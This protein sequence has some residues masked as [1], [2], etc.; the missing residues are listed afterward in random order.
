MVDFII[1]R[2]GNFQ[3]P[4][5]FLIFSVEISRAFEKLNSKLT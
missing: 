3:L 4:F 1:W 5:E 2:Q